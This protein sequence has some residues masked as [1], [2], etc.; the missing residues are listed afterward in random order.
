MVAEPGRTISASKWFKSVGDKIM[1][2]EFD[3]EAV[4]AKII[5]RF[6]NLNINT[7]NPQGLKAFASNACNLV[8][9]E[10][11]SPSDYLELAKLS[12][13][14]NAYKSLSGR[15]GARKGAGRKPVDPIQKRNA[16]TYYVT[17]AEKALMDEFF[18]TQIEAK[19]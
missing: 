19:R 16:A 8:A 9:V 10:G 1:T 3:F 13:R 2:K 7:D 11:V 6:P 4:K 12:Y 5:K 14:D 15:G 17:D 18:K